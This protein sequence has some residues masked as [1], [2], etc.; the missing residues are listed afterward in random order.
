MN[1]DAGRN[2][3]AAAPE[4]KDVDGRVDILQGHVGAHQDAVRAD[5]GGVVEEL[6]AAAQV[7]KAVER[8]G[9]IEARAAAADLGFER[10]GAEG[11]RGRVVL[12]FVARLPA[13]SFVEAGAVAAAEASGEGMEDE[14]VDA[15]TCAQAEKAEQVAAS[16]A[17]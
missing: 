2:V 8:G 3:E 12:V 10:E 9:D 17:R 7:E 15:S 16:V 13:V 4:G 14:N 6:G 5:V 1:R 11:A